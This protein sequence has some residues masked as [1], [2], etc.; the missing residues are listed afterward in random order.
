LTGG[1]SLAAEMNGI[2]TVAFSEIE[3]YPC[4][5]LTHHWEDVPNLGDVTK[6]HGY[7]IEPVDIVTFG[8]PCFLAGTLINTKR[9]LIPIE[10]VRTGDEVL[11]HRNRYRKVVKTMTNYSNN[12]L[13]QLNITG[14]HNTFVT[15]EHPYYVR[16]MKRSYSHSEEGKQ[17]NKR[18]WGEP[19]WVL[20]KDLEPNKHYVGI[21]INQEAVNSEELTL[22][23]CWLLGRYIADGYIR[24][25]QRP[26]RPEGQMNNQVIFCVGK[27]KI[28]DFKAEIKDYYAGYTEERTVIKARIINKR[29]MEL[30]LQCGKGAENKKIPQFI[31]ELPTEYLSKFFDGYMSG[32]GC[33]TKN[34]YQ[35]TSTSKTLIYQLAQVIAKIYHTTSNISFCKR[36]PKCIIEGR[37]VNQR[38]TWIIRFK[39]SPTKQDKG[40]Y[41]D[42]Y[43]WSPVHTNERIDYQGNVYNLEVEEDNSYTANNIIV[44]NCQDLSISGRREGLDG[45]RSGLFMEAV[46]IIREMREATNGRYP[47][48]AIWENVT[49]TFSSNKCEDFRTVLEEITETEI[50]M[51]KSGRWAPAGMVRTK[52]CEVAWVTRDSQYWGVPQR[53][54]RIFLVADFAG[55]CAHKIL[56]EQESLP[57]HTKESKSS[58]EDTPAHTEDRTGT[59]GRNRGE[60]D[61]EI[62]QC[63]TTRTGC[64][65]DPET[66]T[67]IPVP[68]VIREVHNTLRAEAGAP[69]HEADWESLIIEPRSQDGVPRIHNNVCPTLN[70]A[71]GGQRTPCVIQSTPLNIIDRHAVT[72]KY[73]VRRL[74]PLECIRLQAFPDNWLDFGGADT[75]KYKAV[76]NSITVSVVEYI[77]KR[78]VEEGSNE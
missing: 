45:A 14:R 51:P 13:R 22:E 15:D 46:R 60:L 21:A 2:K 7:D 48:Y 4:E 8:S 5:V 72:T 37:E 75:A 9:G 52:R 11:T 70:C 49:G 27:S 35:V 73:A 58:W 36:E 50:P 54:K 28:D 6:I 19:E 61:S 1:F 23:E 67:L 53:R 31:L 65:Y 66:E 64:R 43:L 63:L 20:A 42:G 24:N 25:G 38:D 78:I 41:L 33:F 17:T 76:G 62:A 10:E 30:A 68:I 39:K 74:T 71:T 47:R 12:S 16:T 26:N 56:F 3:K 40:V 55:Q 69:K 18:T 34:N 44:H 29:L 59:A 57:R 77:M 32:D